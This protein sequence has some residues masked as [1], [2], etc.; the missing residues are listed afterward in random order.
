MSYAHLPAYSRLLR[1]AHETV[2]ADG[3]WPEGPRQLIAASWRRSMDAGID[4][5]AVA[6]PLALD[7]ARLNDARDC[8]PLRPLLPLLTEALGRMADESAHIVVVTDGEGRVLWREGHH[9]VMRRADQV[10][11][12]DGHAWTEDRIGTNGIGTA[13]ATRRPVH[14]YSE[15]HLVRR[16]HVWSCSSAPIVDPDSGD[17]LGCLDI[18]GTAPSLHPA[19]VAVVSATARL[20]EAHLALRMHEHDERLRRRYEALRSR[21]GILLSSTGRVIAGDPGGLL[22]E[23]VHL[24][25]SGERMLLRDGRV[26]VAEP[27]AEGYLLRSTPSAAAPPI[28]RLTLLGDGP[29]TAAV[30]ERRLP[31]SLRHAEI[32]ALL[33]LHPRGLSA[34]QL[35]FHL[36]GDDG[37]PV[38]IRAEIHRLRT[39][40]RGT[41]GAKPYRLT[42]PVESDFLQVRH[43]LTVNDPALLARIYTGPLLPRSESPEIRRER[44][45]LE[46]QVRACLLLRGSPDDLWAY[47]QTSNGRGDFQ[48][49][50][51]IAASLP[52]TDHR[53]AAAQ[54]RLFAG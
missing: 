52:S 17:V 51:R 27:F 24:P 1:G 15:E 26:A 37:N 23:R 39:Q 9:G 32:L 40:L 11:L 13:L 45:E 16:L 54:A 47:A 3:V 14:V 12:T 41:I 29:P 2:M 48:I 21:P 7:L 10:G 33:A 38:T 20:A 28:L 49:L 6:A 50:E 4:P 8:H 36:Y 22:G 18:S 35:S 5:E 31:L 30:G 43:L 34:E 46:V 42:S 53:A 25:V 44:D 19:T